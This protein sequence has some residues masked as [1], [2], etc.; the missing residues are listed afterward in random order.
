MIASFLTYKLDTLIFQLTLPR[1]LFQ[2]FKTEHLGAVIMYL[3]ILLY[4]VKTER[5]QFENDKSIYEDNP[6]YFICPLVNL[7][8]DS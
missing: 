2:E 6:D 1:S 7:H 5:F 4:T 3:R 8:F